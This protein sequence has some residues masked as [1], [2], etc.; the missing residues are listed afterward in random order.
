MSFE[1]GHGEV[2]ADAVAVGVVGRFVFWVSA[3]FIVGHA[4]ITSFQQ[5]DIGMAVAEI[6]FFP[7]TYI[8]YPWASGLWWLLIVS[9]LGYWASTFVGKMSPVE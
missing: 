9:L 1:A 5:G 3:I 7:L 4:V 8:I 6:V 2:S